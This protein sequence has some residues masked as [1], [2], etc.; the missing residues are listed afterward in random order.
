MKN[1]FDPYEFQI[2]TALSKRMDSL[3]PKNQRTN[4]TLVF[5]TLACC[6]VLD[7]LLNNSG[8]AAYSVDKSIVFRSLDNKGI[9]P[10]FWVEKRTDMNTTFKASLDAAS[11]NKGKS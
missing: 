2:D 11:K 5:F 3:L 1:A 7:D 4:V 6:S 10:V 8:S 9:E